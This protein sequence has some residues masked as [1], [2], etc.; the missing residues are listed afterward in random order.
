MS[1]DEA[2]RALLDKYVELGN[3]LSRLKSD[4]AESND[5]IEKRLGEV[6][7]QLAD[8]QVVLNA[9]SDDVFSLDLRVSEVEDQ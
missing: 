6:Q 5:K 9:V 1:R 8:I 2:L 4:I 3:G 7:Q